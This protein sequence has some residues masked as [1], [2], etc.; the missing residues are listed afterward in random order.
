MRGRARIT[1]E[2]RAAR[3][4]DMHP[5]FRHLVVGLQAGIQPVGKLVEFLVKHGD[6][7]ADY[8]RTAMA[9]VRFLRRG[10]AVMRPR[11]INLKLGGLELI[12]PIEAF[13]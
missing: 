7:R 4:P 10:P 2:M 13:S 1:P 3:V 12:V 8:L 6:D 11:W 9:H 5:Q